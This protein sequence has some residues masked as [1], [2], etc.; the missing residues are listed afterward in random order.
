[1]VARL[2]I[3]IALTGERDPVRITQAVLD[4]LSE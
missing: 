3:Q 4:Q 1:M 2:T